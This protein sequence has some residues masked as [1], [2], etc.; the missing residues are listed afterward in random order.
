M[1]T[2][3]ERD[4]LP[5]AAAMTT[6][7]TRPSHDGQCRNSLWLRNVITVNTSSR[8]TRPIET[9]PGATGPGLNAGWTI[10]SASQASTAIATQPGD[11]AD[12]DSTRCVLR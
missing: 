1:S 3:S 12:P 8:S 7:S 4:R 5:A 9:R 2:P 6:E 11:D 10:R